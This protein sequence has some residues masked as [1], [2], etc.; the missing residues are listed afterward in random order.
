MKKVIVS[1]AI[2]SLIVMSMSSCKSTGYGCRGRESWSHM[3]KR[4]NS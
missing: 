2:V 1:I 4:I 3:V